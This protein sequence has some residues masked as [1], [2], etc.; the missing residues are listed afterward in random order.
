MLV[1]PL[2]G[3]GLLLLL[4]A[5]VFSTV[6]WPKGRGGPVNRRQNRLVWAAFRSLG[7]RRDGST[8]DGLL[9]V[10]G[11][12]IVVTTLAVWVLWLVVGFALVY[13]PWIR[14][15]LVSPGTLRVPWWEAVYFSGYTAATLG[16]GDLV[17]DRQAL[18]LL[19]PVEAFGGFALLSISVTYFLAV[20]RELVRKEALAA[21]VSSYLSDGGE[22]PLRFA[23]D[24]GAD[25][26]A[27]WCESVSDAL[28]QVLLAHFQYPV[29]HF[30][31]SEQGSRALPVQ[32]GHLLAMRERLREADL[33]PRLAA[34]AEHPGYRALA[35]SLEQYVTEVD[36]LFV[37]PAGT[38]PQDGGRARDDVEAA[39]RR[40]LE[41]MLHG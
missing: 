38:R 15:F 20:Y 30:F 10:A 9:A 21:S 16:F 22:A 40:L 7:R 25:A 27:R 14:S 13:S 39:H 12:V 41:Y 35:S 24:G 17:P 6:F 36:R 5:D 1:L 8:R 31:R 37:P 26:V 2:L 33:P 34:F 11:P 23:G 32:L 19:A 29:L 3:T 18:R 4:A 28:S